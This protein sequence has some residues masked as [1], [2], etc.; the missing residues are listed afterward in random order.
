M[1]PVSKSS[2]NLQLVLL[3]AG[4]EAAGTLTVQCI[5]LHD[6]DCVH[7][8]DLAMQSSCKVSAQEADNPCSSPCPLSFY[9][10]SWAAPFCSTHGSAAVRF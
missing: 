7:L 8:R 4:I 6:K 9:K 5:C 10:A 2:G 3:R 1:L